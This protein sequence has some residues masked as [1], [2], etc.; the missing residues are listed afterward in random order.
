MVYTLPIQYRKVFGSDRQFLAIRFDEQEELLQEQR[1]ILLM[2]L[3]KPAA[4]AKCFQRLTSLPELHASI[5][6]DDG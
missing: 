3:A 6:N 5:L 2:R 4:I 1:R